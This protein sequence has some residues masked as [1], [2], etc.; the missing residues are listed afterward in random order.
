LDFADAV[1]FFT[2]SRSWAGW[3]A[4]IADFLDMHRD[5]LEGIGRRCID[6]RRF[7]EEFSSEAWQR[8]PGALC[9]TPLR[10]ACSTAQP[11]RRTI[12]HYPYVGGWDNAVYV[13]AM[14]T[15]LDPE[16]PANVTSDENG[17]AWLTA[18]KGRGRTLSYGRADEAGSSG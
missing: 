4:T 18:G 14:E 12:Q 6:A 5:E 17:E 8:S 10:L 11:A 15:R 1:T 13:V 16:P 3:R 2:R 7:M 9:V